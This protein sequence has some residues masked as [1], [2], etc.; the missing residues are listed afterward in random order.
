MN[1]DFGEVLTRA[2]Q[3]TWKNKILW[4]FSALPVLLSFLIFPVV[5]LPIFLTD[6]NS[7]REPFFVE[8]PIYI[9]IFMGF[10]FFIGILSFAL[11]AVSSSSVTL[12]AV[13]VEGGASALGIA[14]LFDDG[15][16]YWLRMMGVML[17]VS[18]TISLVFAVIFGCFT[19]IGAVTM[20]LGFICLQ[21]LFLL[22]YPIMMVLYGFIEVS[23]AAVVVD[24]VGV[25][26]AIRRGWDLVKANFWRILLISFI[27]YMGISILS[28]II[29]LPF[30][31]PFFFF[32]FL[33]E[34]RQF[35]PNPHT[36]SLFVGG[37]SLILFPVIALI[38]GITIT[39][40]K[41]TYTIVYL[42]LK[43]VK[44]TDVKMQEAP[45]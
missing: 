18:F 23:L 24:D 38:Q 8:Q 31:T 2:G 36:I 7:N 34:G 27:V 21:P 20:G 39:F 45:I 5:F 25:I 30:M 13:Q 11:T 43:G 12:G 26:D 32:P 15:K 10:A 28:T 4:L 6:F 1:F 16:K 42:R 33:M 19:L 41:S 40:L 22:M 9:F 37:F 3:I 17:L 14:K 44:K 35:D 29:V